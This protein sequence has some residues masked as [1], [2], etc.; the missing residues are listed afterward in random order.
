MPP[1]VNLPEVTFQRV[2]TL[3]GLLFTEAEVIER[4]L[5]E[6]DRSALLVSE[7]H[8]A[9]EV[10]PAVS[11]VKTKSTTPLIRRTGDISYRSPRERGVT[12][13][14]LGQRVVADTVKDLYERILRLLV[15]GGHFEQ[16]RPLV[17]YRTSAQRY[18]IANEPVHPG[19]NDFVIPMNYTG[20]YMETHKSYSTAFK[21]LKTFVGK[22]GIELNYLG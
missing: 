5:D 21:Q 14:I 10:S 11:N 8:T 9:P 22:A 19:G 18:L 4:L 13:E 15:D 2:K 1:T 17:P 7:S 12:V 6:H 3:A 16:L 20:L